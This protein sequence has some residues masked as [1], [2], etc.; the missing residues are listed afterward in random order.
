VV[1]EDVKQ[2][3]FHSRREAPSVGPTVQQ[4]TGPD[5]IVQGGV[6]FYATPPKGNDGPPLPSLSPPG[7]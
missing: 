4:P 2:R 1:T 3:Y 5:G 6:D 7:Q